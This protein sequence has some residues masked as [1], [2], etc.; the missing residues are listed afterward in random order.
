MESQKNNLDIS[1]V[2]S[3]RYET[4]RHLDKLRWQML[5]LAIASGAIATTVFSKPHTGELLWAICGFGILWLLIGFSMIRI[6]SGIKLNNIMLAEV[7]K[8]LGDTSIPVLRSRLNSASFIISLFIILVGSFLSL[9][10]IC[11][12]AGVC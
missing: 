1:A 9:Y 11:A 4:F 7:G 10:A 5:Q 3:Q 8:Q 2:Y 12:I 6:Q